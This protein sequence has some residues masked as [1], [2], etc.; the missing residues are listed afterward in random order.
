MSDQERRDPFKYRIR[1]LILA[2]LAIAPSHGYDLSKKIQEVTAGTIKPSPG[3][4]YPVL[5]DLSKEGLVEEELV[6]EKGRARKIYKLTRKGMEYLLQELNLFYEIMNNV[7][8][9]ATEA[10][11]VLE[12]KLK[13]TLTDCVPASI[14]DSLR[15]IKESAET[16]LKRIEEANKICGEGD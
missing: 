1:F 8:A 5:H 7:Y 14:V 15:R 13:G 10:R 16:Y 11:R 6:V 9:I 4:I 3:S 2:I 12:A